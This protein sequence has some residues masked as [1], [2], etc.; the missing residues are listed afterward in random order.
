MSRLDA[1]LQSRRAAGWRPVAGL[2]CLTLAAFGL[3]A[4]YAHLDEVSVAGGQVVPQGNVKV[5]Q[6]LEG[7]IIAQLHVREG[8]EVKKG[9][10]LVTLALGADR[11]DREELKVRT[12]GLTLRR[13]RLR[14]EI[15]GAAPEFDPA[16]E[17]RRPDIASAERGALAA[18][19]AE[20]A[21]EI[22]VYDQQTEQAHEAVREL[23]ARRR[24]LVNDLAFARRQEAMSA[25][26]LKDGLTSKMAHVEAQRDVARIEGELETLAATIPKAL[27]GRE[28]A[29]RRIEEAKRR[30]SRRAADELSPVEIEIRRT[31]ELMARASEQQGRTEIA[32]PIDGVVK[33][34]GYHTIGG[35]VR[36]GAP[37]MEIVPTGDRLVVEAKLDPADRGYVRE[38]QPALVKI[39]T[40]EYARY[41]GLG[42][43]VVLIAPGSDADARGRPYFRVVVETDKAWLG[44]SEGELRILPGMEAT[45]DIHTGT[46][47]V[48]DY[49]LKPVLKIGAEAFRER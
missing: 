3:W 7:G 42:G 43:R 32:S 41:G 29:R 4:F 2:I 37:I 46:R 16:L 22:A 35:V 1:L 23:Q 25:N 45:V 39:S 6:H 19:R 15:G 33:K 30:F 12:D 17:A 28:E 48:L 36:P 8:D 26:L 21:S 14:A 47:S 31:A 38:G 5:I 44:A 24:A 49:L 13:A 34:L 20:L 18:R 10:P 40:Y 27:A 11:L 9:A